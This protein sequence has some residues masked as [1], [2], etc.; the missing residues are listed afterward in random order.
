LSLSLVF[1]GVVGFI[2]D[3]S[4]GLLFFNQNIIKGFTT[5]NEIMLLSLMVGGLSGIIGKESSKELANH[6]S[7]WIS[8]KRGGQKTAQMF[9]A[10][11]VSIF[12]ILLAN[13]TIAIIFCGEIARDIA[14]KHHIP[15]HYSAAWLDIFSCVFQGLI[16]YGAQILLAST[17]VGV[18]PLSVVP[19]VYYCYILGIVTILHIL[20]V[21]VKK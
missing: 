1:A 5:M 21:K 16:P 18:S 2:N 10:K 3:S 13:N 14:K 7:N 4:H 15:T 8:K 12:D 11:I 19:H 9:I 20:F 17:V 6:L